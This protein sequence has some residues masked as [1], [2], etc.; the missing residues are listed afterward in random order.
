MLGA[1]LAD[2][3]NA[4]SPHRDDAVVES[5]RGGHKAAGFNDIIASSSYILSLML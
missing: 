4:A 2:L 1:A 5:E 3:H